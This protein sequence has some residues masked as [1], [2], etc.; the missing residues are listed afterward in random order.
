MVNSF[1]IVSTPRGSSESLH[2]L[3]SRRT[4]QSILTHDQH[5]ALFQ[6]SAPSRRRH[7]CLD[8]FALARVHVTRMT[9]MYIPLTSQTLLGKLEACSLTSAQKHAILLLQK[10]I[11]LT[12]QT[13]L[14][15]CLLTHKRTRTRNTYCSSVRSSWANFW[16]STHWTYKFHHAVP[17]STVHPF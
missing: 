4:F 17:G 1:Y 7:C 15:R 8:A 14:S 6:C 2:H 16:T 3:Y 13:L 5:I 12:S 9:L 11:P 10:H